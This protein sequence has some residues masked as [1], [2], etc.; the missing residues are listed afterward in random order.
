MNKKIFAVLAVFMVF[1][2]VGSV[3]AAKVVDTGTKY[4]WNGQDGYIK[5]EWK[6][7]QYN[8]NFL[9]TYVAKYLRDEDTKRYEFGDDEE[10]VFAKVSKDSLKTTTI[11]DWFVDFDLD[12]VQISYCKTKLTGAQYYW[13]VFRPQTLLKANI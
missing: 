11:A 9:K 8:D 3:S 6:T 13:R 7:Y 2:I 4:A 10:F 12:P 1:V 5:L